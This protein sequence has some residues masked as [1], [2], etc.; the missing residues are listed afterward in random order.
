MPFPNIFKEEVANEVIRR[1]NLLS[2]SM[3]PKWGKMT[4]AQML[5]H[6]CVTYEMIYDNIHPKPK[7][8]MKFILKALVKNKVVS[9]TPY[10][11]NLRTAPQFLMKET[12]NFG[13]EKERLINYIKR[14]QQVGINSLVNTE[15]HS[16]GKL[17]ADE[18]NNMLYKHLNH[19]LSQF[20]V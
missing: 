17:T 10:K 8:F 2:S 6:C 7:G 13:T 14:T 19:H 9:E 4:A 15:S 3:V 20:G 12:K 18:W 1:I 11:Q 5:A 16:F